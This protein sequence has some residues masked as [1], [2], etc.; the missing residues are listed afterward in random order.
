M[1][2]GAGFNFPYPGYLLDVERVIASVHVQLVQT[3]DC[4][5]DL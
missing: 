1:A 3:V 4:A 2:Q 5:G